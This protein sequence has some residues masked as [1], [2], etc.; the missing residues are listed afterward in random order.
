MGLYNDL[1][2][3]IKEAFD[4][5]LAD[6]V[7]AVDVVLVQQTYDPSV[8]AP[9]DGGQTYQTR[10]V[11]EP[12]DSGMVDGEVIQIADTSFLILQSELATIPRLGD[13]VQTGDGKQYS[14]NSVISDPAQV[15]WTLI[16]R[17][18]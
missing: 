13:T 2:I 16:A 15:T 11:I 8:G 18:V 4:T 12:V 3:A 9:V 17:S 7:N 5:D 6:A 1:N 10:A 14:I